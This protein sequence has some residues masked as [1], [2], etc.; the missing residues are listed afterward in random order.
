MYQQQQRLKDHQ[1]VHRSQSRQGT[2]LDYLLTGQVHVTNRPVRFRD[3]LWR[4]CLSGVPPIYVSPNVYVDNSAVASYSLHR[5]VQPVQVRAA[6][7]VAIS[8]RI[9]AHNQDA[10]SLSLRPVV[11]DMLLWLTPETISRVI[12]TPSPRGTSAH[13]PGREPN[14]NALPSRQSSVLSVEANSSE[15]ASDISALVDG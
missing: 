5:S 14:L 10:T 13:T 2:D 9:Y 15:Q 1:K 12:N 4:V 3:I 8:A 6:A 11:P 7:A